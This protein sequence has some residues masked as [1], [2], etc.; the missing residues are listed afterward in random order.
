MVLT[1]AGSAGA[2]AFTGAA[3]FCWRRVFRFSRLAS[4]LVLRRASLIFRSM[5]MA[6]Y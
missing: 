4:A 3:A 5:F 2:H 6:R 1:A